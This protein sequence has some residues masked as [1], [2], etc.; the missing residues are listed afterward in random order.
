MISRLDK[1]LIPDWRRAHRMV[2]VQ[3]WTLALAILGAWGILPDSLREYLP[4][5][6]G[7]VVSVTVFVLALIGTAGRLVKQTSLDSQKEHQDKE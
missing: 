7:S 3:A 2:S 1:A 4:H 6:M 5:M